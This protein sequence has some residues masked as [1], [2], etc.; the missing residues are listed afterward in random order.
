MSAQNG[1]VSGAACSGK[2][3]S[4]T[5]F[6]LSSSRAGRTVKLIICSPCATP[7]DYVQAE[8]KPMRLI[9][10]VDY[11]RLSSLLNLQG[12]CTHLICVQAQWG[13]LHSKTD[14]PMC[15][16]TFVVLENGTIGRDLMC[17]FKRYGHGKLCAFEEI[18]AL[19]GKIEYVGKHE[20]R[21]C[22]NE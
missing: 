17:L 5:V 3:R 8:Y 12:F 11:V 1:L 9:M 7:V 18:I 6:N 2:V 15:T 14:S 19:D 4:T 13:F 20:D 10:L 21:H 22:L 16:A